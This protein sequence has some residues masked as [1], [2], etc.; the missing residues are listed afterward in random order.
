MKRHF[1][2]R[3]PL[4]PLLCAALLAV[5]PS[6]ARVGAQ[7]ERPGDVRRLGVYAITN[8]RIIPVVGQPIERGAIVIRDGLIADFGAAVRP[9]SDARVI[10]G[11]GLTVYPGVAD[12]NANIGFA[13][14][15]PAAGPSPGGA[16]P[17][18]AAGAAPNSTRPV[19]VQPELL[20][21][22]LIRPNGDGVESARTAGVTSAL[23]IPRDGLLI[24]RSA[25]VNLAGA[26]PQ[27]MIIRSPV[28]LHVAFVTPPG[29]GSY[30]SSLMGVFS[31]LR[32]MFSDAQHY[33]DAE[34]AYRQN[35][36]GA[37]R[38]D[39]DPALAALVPALNREVPVVMYAD[40]EREILRA[41]DFAQEFNLRPIIAGGREATKTLARL[42]TARAP[43][44][45][46]L[47]FPKRTAAA[48][49]EADPEP[50][51]VLRARVAAL[52]TAAALAAADVP[53]AF[54]SGGAPYGEFLANAAKTVENGLARDAALQAMTIRPA[55]FFNV[56]DRLG[57]IETGK[58][59]NLTV[60]RGDL[61]DPKSKLAF[62][63]I[64]GKMM[65]VR[66]AGAAPGEL[67]GMWTQR[68]GGK[69][70]LN[71]TKDGGEPRGELKEAT[72]ARATADLRLGLAEDASLS[73]VQFTATVT[74]NG[75][76][77]PATFVGVYAA[78][79]IRGAFF[80]A[81]A[82]EPEI[83]FR[84]ASPPAGATPKLSLSGAWRLNVSLEAQTVA[85]T[86]T[87][88]QE[89]ERLT[90]DIATPF[91]NAALTDGVATGASFRCRASLNVGGQPLALSI[92]GSVAGDRMEG[93]ISSSQGDAG[94]TG[95]RPQ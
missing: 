47:N 92:V 60:T 65:D 85:V 41:L 55:E 15:P 30:P 5:A 9:P 75:A 31:L 88:R 48:A 67:A 27:E 56:A 50:L 45:L 93:T 13:A 52:K 26:T 16:P 59:A 72:E 8:A 37:R 53:F 70:T 91:G 90:G 22:D 62:V 83:A 87:L 42:R 10:D 43:V 94:F 23:A 68:D 3:L 73:T 35:P 29:F 36:R 46:S 64:D 58:I 63:F 34:A 7:T 40:T 14:T 20:A 77:T 25:F 38:P 44:L 81:G 39:A 82:P 66:P 76:P 51:T 86:L 84:R 57:S 12:A 19:G 89:G 74:R 95:T 80:V 2:A 79:E 49:P 4:I 78:D 54:Q 28:A 61:L 21:A 33:R 18:R 24:G 17:A 1:S 11:S 6:G 69:L 32:Q 71:F